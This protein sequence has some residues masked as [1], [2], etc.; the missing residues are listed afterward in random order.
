LMDSKLVQLQREIKSPCQCLQIV[1]TPAC[2]LCYTIFAGNASM[3][4]SVRGLLLMTA[5]FCLWRPSVEIRL[6]RDSFNLCLA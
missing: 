5:T 1:S 4:E 6:L 3:E 2:T